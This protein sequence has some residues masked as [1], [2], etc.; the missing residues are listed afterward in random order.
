MNKSFNDNSLKIKNKAGGFH[1]LGEIY[2]KEIKKLNSMESIRKKIS[3]IIIKFNLH[4]LGSFYYKF[5]NNNGFTGLVSLVESHVAI[6]TWPE[7]YYLTLDV[8]LCN[9][10]KDNSEIC[11]QIFNEITNLFNPEKINKTIIIR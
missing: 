4:E 2:T 6:H 10:S 3:K 11:E 8:F 9:Y 1:V 5:S 7:L